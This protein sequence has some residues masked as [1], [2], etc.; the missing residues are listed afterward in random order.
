MSIIDGLTLINL[1]IVPE[2]GENER[3]KTS[4]IF[5]DLS[6]M[7]DESLLNLFFDGNEEIQTRTLSLDELYIR[8]KDICSESINKIA[9][10]F[11]F[12][13]TNIFRELLKDIALKS[14]TDLN[15]RTECARTLYDDNKEIGY[16]CFHCIS[17]NMMEFPI[18]LQVEIIKTL[19]ETKKYYMETLSKFI[20]II[21]DIRLDCEY[22]YKTLMNIQNLSNSEMSYLQDGYLAFF[23][24]PKT[25][26]RYKILSSQFLLQRIKKSTNIDLMFTLNGKTIS[27]EDVCNIV[28]RDLVSFALDTELDY[29]LRADVSDLLL[30]L[31][32]YNSK[33]IGKE[34]ISLLGREGGVRTLYTNRQNVHDET[35][36]ESVRKFIL[37]L[38]SLKS[39]SSGNGSENCFSEIKREIEESDLKESERDLVK[40]SLL[41]ISIDQTLYEGGQ[42]LQTIFNKIWRIILD[43]EHRSLLKKR[44]IEELIDMANTCSSG[45]VSRVVNILCGFEVEGRTFSLEIGWKRQIQSN[46]VARLTRR[47]KDLE[48]EDERDEILEEMSMSGNILSK[49]R[50]SFF[51]RNNL[52]PIRDELFSEFV[53]GGYVSNDEFEEFFRSAISFFEEGS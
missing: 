52:V 5:Q 18:P 13:P 44:M 16:E 14:K 21:T 15:I 26:I 49:P 7:T 42:T 32:D 2:K 27:N 34:V 10:M 43:H 22:R 31:G 4:C 9:S 47:I 8:N 19:M 29:D 25:F 41:R 3:V 51:F 39:D 33:T 28:N 35:I 45:H 23:V 37:F 24:H 38:G 48:L 46:L 53:G 6:Q 20:S 30:R 1:V 11:S 36:D 50:L 12:A 17:I 40:S